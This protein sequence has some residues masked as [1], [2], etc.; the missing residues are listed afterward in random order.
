MTADWYMRTGDNNIM[1]LRGCYHAGHVGLLAPKR[2]R[3]EDRGP[4]EDGRRDADE[5]GCARDRDT[6][7]RLNRLDVRKRHST[8]T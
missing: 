1:L 7:Q 3:R 5:D 8:L 6:R 2:A 4:D